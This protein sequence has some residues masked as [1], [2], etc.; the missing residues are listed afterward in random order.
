MASLLQSITHLG[1]AGLP[2]KVACPLHPRPLCRHSVNSNAIQLMNGWSGDAAPRRRC[3]RA[4]ME[5]A[6][7]FGWPTATGNFA[8]PASCAS[9]SFVQNAVKSSSPPFMLDVASGPTKTLTH[10][11][12]AAVQLPESGPSSMSTVC[13]ARRTAWSRLIW[14]LG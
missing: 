7:H 5:R 3:P 10:T 4:M 9:P 11:T 12:C 8:K 2:F 6:V 13:S 14:P 1:L